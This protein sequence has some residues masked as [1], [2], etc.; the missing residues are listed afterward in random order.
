[1]FRASFIVLVAL[2][3]VA[4]QGGAF[5]EPPGQG[6]VIAELDFSQARLAYDGFGRAAAIPAWRKFE[7]STYAEYGVAD[8]LTLIGEPSW[9]SFRTATPGASRTSVGVAEAGARAKLFEWDENVLSAQATFRYAPGGQGAADH[10]DM[11]RRTQ[12]DVRLLYGR[13]IEVFGWG[14]YVDTQVGFRSAGARG[15]QARFDATFAVRPFE[16][17]T[18]MLQTFTT[19]T[20]GRIGGNFALAQKAK[21]SVVV[22]VTRSLSL[23]FGAVAGLRG[24]N[25]PAERGFASA[26]WWRF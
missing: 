1:M 15:H 23:Q 26:I 2:A 12:I 10:A 8:W 4:A 6:Q 25:A 3:P 14:G 18:L 7:L 22:D 13:K 16:R 9:F 5:L 17:I 20:P 19:A 24:V 11:A 21:A